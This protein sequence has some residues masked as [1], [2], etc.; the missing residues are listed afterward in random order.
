MTINYSNYFNTNRTRLS[1]ALFQKFSALV[2]DKVGIYLKPE[3]RE[4][5][6]ARLGK[7]MRAL[8]INSFRE[9]YE[10]LSRDTSGEEL[11]QMIDAVSTNFTSFFRE[12]DHF[13]FLVSHVLPDLTSRKRRKQEVV[14]WSAASSSG[15]EPYT[16]ALV[17]EDFFEKRAEGGYRILATDVSTRVLAHAERGVYSMDRVVKVPERYLRK[18]FQKGHG[19]AAGHVRVKE[20]LRRRISFERFN[21]MDQ[22]PWDGTLDIIFCRNTMIYFNRETQQRLV[23]KFYRALAPGGY[24]FIGHSESITG[25]KHEFVPTV[26]TVY[27]KA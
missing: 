5:L 24:L 14:I 3:K 15:E 21:L 8:G 17:T 13:D 27:Q 4:L 2:Y 10:Y 18:Y 9:Y 20:H 6:N 25:L 26:S 1:D 19:S 11:V 12:K 22:F 23:S 7:R 16:I